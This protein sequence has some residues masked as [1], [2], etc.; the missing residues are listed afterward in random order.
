MPCVLAYTMLLDCERSSQERYGQRRV[1]QRALDCF[2]CCMRNITF[3]CSCACLAHIYTRAPGDGLWVLSKA[4]NRHRSVHT[5]VD[6]ARDDHGPGPQHRQRRFVAASTHSITNTLS[7]SLSLSLSVCVC[8]CVCV[9]MCV[10]GWVGCFEYMYVRET[11]VG[12]GCSHVA[13]VC[14]HS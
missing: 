11:M 3:L 8:V 10:R 4:Q 14:E 6:V 7:L 9:C 12:Q 13:F 1:A 2:C 5:A